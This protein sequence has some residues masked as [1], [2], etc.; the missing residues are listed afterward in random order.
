MSCRH[1][2]LGAKAIAHTQMLVLA[3]TCAHAYSH[4]LTHTL[5]LSLFLSLSLSHTHTRIHVQ[6][7]ALSRE[8]TAS[9]H[10]LR[11]QLKEQVL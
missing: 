1:T 6:V 5:S 10:T 2:G 4:M 11:Q 7:L 8:Q 3:R 9:L